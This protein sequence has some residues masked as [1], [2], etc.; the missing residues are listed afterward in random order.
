MLAEHPL[1]GHGP[2]G[3]ERDRPGPQPPAFPAAAD[4][5]VLDVADP[6]RDGHRGS[7][8]GRASSKVP[9]LLLGSRSSFPCG[10][11]YAA[12]PSGSDSRSAPFEREDG[13]LVQVE[14]DALTP[15]EMR[16]LYEAAIAPLWDKTKFERVFEREH[17]ERVVL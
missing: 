11:R 12:T 2:I 15:D 3:I 8:S 13:R 6:F 10:S 16:A 1:V 17:A 9:R 7:E 4:P 5:P 14:L